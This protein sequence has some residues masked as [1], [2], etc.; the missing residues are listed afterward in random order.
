M[1]LKFY[2]FLLFLI[3]YCQGSEAQTITIETDT[4]YSGTYFSTMATTTGVS[5]W[6]IYHS[7]NI[8][9]TGPSTINVSANSDPSNNIHMYGQ[10]NVSTTPGSYTLSFTDSAGVLQT[11][12][13]VFWILPQPIPQIP[14]LTFPLNNQVITNTNFSLEWDGSQGSVDYYFELS[15]DSIF[16]NIYYYTNQ[17]YRW[18]EWD[19]QGNLPSGK[20]YWHVKCRNYVTSV[21][22]AFSP[23]QSFEINAS[24]S[25]SNALP[26]TT[27]QGQNNFQ[28]NISG[29]STHF[30][31]GSPTESTFLRQS[32]TIINPF[33]TNPDGNFILKE[34]FNIPVSAPIGLYDLVYYNQ[35]DDTLIYYNAVNING[36]N[37]F[38]G[39]VFLDLNFNGVFDSSDV[40]YNNA[41]LNIS[42][43]NE[44]SDS[45]GDFSGYLPSGT[46][47][48]SVENLLPYLNSVPADYTINFPGTGASLTN[49]DFAV[50]IDSLFHDLNIN[51]SANHFVRVGVSDVIRIN[52]INH[53]PIS[54]D[55]QVK[56]LPS[57][58]MVLDSVSDPG[59]SLSGDTMIW[60]FT[61]LNF[62]QFNEIRLYYSI[63]PSLPIG[64]NLNL[65]A[66]IVGSVGPDYTPGRNVDFAN[67][68]VRGPFD[69]NIKSVSPENLSPALIPNGISLKYTIEFQN[70]GNDV[71]FNIS[72][73]DTISQNVDLS[74]IQIIGASANYRMII[75]PGRVVEFRFDNINLPDSNS[76][77]PGSHGL[78]SYTINAL[79]TLTVQDRI[80]N[81]AYIYFDH[82]APIAT[83]TSITTIGVGVDELSSDQPTISVYP[84]P[85]TSKTKI[86]YELNQSTTVKVNL[87]N[88][89][90]KVIQCLF[91]GQQV[92]GIHELIFDSAHLPSGIYFISVIDNAGVRTKRVI[93]MK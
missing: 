19:T 2:L 24:P 83:N 75:Y 61:G 23:T 20:T 70:T 9:L 26:N 46:F 79:T 65:N 36:S 31:Q 52:Y 30:E 13:D 40:P 82:N 25:L 6:G 32:S 56:F 33:K 91:E 3:T 4:V 16:S 35:I 72:I 58:G 81:T 80:L 88:Y 71:A 89:Q 63:P 77:E 1:K 5:L 49:R 17:Y 85:I 73:L 12:P 54:E 15:T 45:S 37:S 42:P 93:S 87:I 27:F 47:N 69:P 29:S 51:I 55:G 43:Y 11:F 64:T 14:F 86:S 8:T 78:I 76:N 7:F 59:F 22:S 18:T 66:W 44:I 21:S 84:N 74:S 90:G 53:G 62:L 34:H 57:P 67:Q 68:E 28:L 50:Q 92:Q 41:I 48:L 10:T 60:N 38:S 39:K